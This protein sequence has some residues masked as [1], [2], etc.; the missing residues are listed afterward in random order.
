MP[1]LSFLPFTRSAGTLH[2]T[3]RRSFNHAAAPEFLD[4]SQSEPEQDHTGTRR[5]SERQVEFHRPFR[6]NPA[7]IERPPGLYRIITEDEPVNGAPFLAYRR[8]VTLIEGPSA[9]D[10]GST[11][12][13]AID[14]MELEE[15]LAIDK[16]QRVSAPLKHSGDSS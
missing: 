9:T 11:I 6:L 5:R 1:P 12:L 7:E 13:E 16:A 14:P 4:A 2:N 8:V 3:P 15:A 10:P